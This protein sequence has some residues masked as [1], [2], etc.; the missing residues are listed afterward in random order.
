MKSTWKKLLTMIFLGLVLT[1]FAATKDIWDAFAASQNIELGY[2]ESENGKTDSLTEQQV[3]AYV[4]SF[5]AEMDR[6][7]ASNNVC[8]SLYKEQNEYL[9]RE[10]CNDE[11][12]Y[13]VGR[14]VLER[15]VYWIIPHLDGKTVELHANYRSS[16]CWVEESESGRLEVVAPV[17]RNEIT[18]TMV[19]EDGQWKLRSMDDF[20][21][22]ELQ[23]SGKSLEISSMQYDTFEQALSAAQRI[24]Q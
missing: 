18:A 10:V 17:C 20:H 24:T 19:R 9:L 2:F 3:Q 21:M 8:L 12:S 5:N 14:S 22:E 1:G 6:Y 16:G 7:Y 11:I 15:P 13:C 23:K 4:D